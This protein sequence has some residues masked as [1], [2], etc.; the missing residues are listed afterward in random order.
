MP[1]KRELYDPQWQAIS[2]RIRFERAGGR[3]ESCG[4]EH[5]AVGARDANGQWRNQQQRQARAGQL[6]LIAL[7]GRAR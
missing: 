6:E 1:I 5:G 3:C 4:V 2:N 7:R